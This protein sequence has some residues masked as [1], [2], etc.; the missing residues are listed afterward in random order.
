M[1]VYSTLHNTRTT[2]SLDLKY[3]QVVR[4]S[5]V[6]FA[7]RVLDARVNKSLT[8]SI[9]TSLDESSRPRKKNIYTRYE[10]N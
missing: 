4:N 7:A 6:F 1:H 9:L 2:A 8:T 10:E 3:P 5:W